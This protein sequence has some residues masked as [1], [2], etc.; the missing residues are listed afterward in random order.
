MGVAA[1]IIV[2]AAV[3]IWRLQDLLRRKHG[4]FNGAK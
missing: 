1:T 4:A 2:V 3:V